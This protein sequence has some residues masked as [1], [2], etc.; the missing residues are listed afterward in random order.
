ME[1]VTINMEQPAPTSQGTPMQS[2]SLDANT[3]S[4]LVASRPIMI[5]KFMP[6]DVDLWYNQVEACFAVHGLVDQR[7]KYFQ[8]V[9]S[10]DPDVIK[11]VT[12]YVSQP[13]GHG[14]FQGLVDALRSAF[15]KSEGDKLDELFALT[16]GDQKPSH[17]YY[18]MRRLWL[19]NDPDASKVLRQLF[20]RKLPS[21]VAVLLR[22][23]TNIDLKDFLKAADDM[24]DQCKQ[25]LVFARQVQ[26]K[27]DM[28]GD[29]HPVDSITT[30]KVSKNKL[31]HDKRYP[32]F[33]TE[34]ICN[35]H[36]RWG[37]KA[38]KCRPGCKFPGATK[39]KVNSV[40]PR[41][42]AGIQNKIT[43]PPTWNQHKAVR[44]DQ[45][46]NGKQ[47][48]IDTGSAYSILPVQPHEKRTK[49]NNDMFKG[50]QGVAIP[51]YGQ[52]EIVVDIGTGRKLKHKFFI[53]GVEDPLLGMDFLLEHRLAVD[54]IHDCLIDVDT[55]ISTPVNAVFINKVTSSS[56][57]TGDL[58]R[59]WN[60]FPGLCE[61]TIEKLSSKP[62]HNVEHDIIVKPGTRPTHAKARRL[63]GQKLDA[64]REEINIMLRLGIIQPS[65]SDWASP[66]H[67]VPKGEG[68]YRPCGDFRELNAATVPDRYPLPHI[69]D[70]TRDLAGSKIFSKVDLVRAFHQVPLSKEA[71]PKTAIIT[72]FGLFEFVRMPFG[73]C[74][75]AQAFQ[76]FMDIVTKGLEGVFVYVD[77]ILVVSKN[78]TEHEQRLRQLFARLSQYG[79][80]VNPSKSVLGTTEVTFLG[81]T[82]NEHGV[83]P[84]EDKVKAI[85][86][87]P[88]PTTFGKLSEFLGMTNFYHRFIPQCSE[89]AK[90]LYDILK[91]HVAKKNSKKGIPV[92][93]WKK[94]QQNAF[95]NLKQALSEAV[96][97]TYPDPNAMTRLVTDA[98]DVAVGA[99]LE[100]H[101]EGN[102]KPISFYSR[103]LRTPEQKYS[104]YDRELLSIKLAL[105]NFRHIVEGISSEQFH[106]ATDHK[107]LT[108]G[109]NFSVT[110]QNPSQLN[111]ILRTWQY[112]SELTTD[113]RHISGKANPVADALSRNPVNSI[114]HKSLLSLIE[115]EQK[116]IN[117]R[118]TN[119]EKWPDHWDIQKH[120]G[121]TL[122][123][124]TR[125]QR[126][127]PVIPESI[128]KTV[129]SQIHNV[130]HAGVKATK[131]AISSSFVW[132][133]MSA[134]IADWVR[135]C[136]DCQSSKI[137]KHHKAPLNQLPH[138]TGKFQ[139]IH[140]D[141]VG[142]LPVNDG[143]SYL[144]TV[145]DRFSRWPAAIPI[146][147][148]T[149]QDCARALIEGWIQHYGTPRSMVTD[150]GRQFTSSMWQEVCNMIGTTHELT[151]AYHPQANGMVERFHR[152]LKTCLKAKAY[153]ERWLQAL[154]LIMLGIR[155]AVKEDIGV[156]A[157]DIV[158]GQQLRLPSAFFPDEP[159]QE[160]GNYVSDLQNYMANMKYHVPKWHGREHDS[161][162][163]LRN[164]DT[165]THVFVLESGIKTPLQKPYKGPFEVKE[166][167]P[168]FYKILLPNGRTDNVS[169]DRLKPAYSS[170]M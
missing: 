118:P 23:I 41:S 33:N 2:T 92:A 106:V 15:A 46:V 138:P 62:I 10:L 65:K 102:W 89:L 145:V 152:Q 76:R 149:S 59:L 54:P 39:E 11:H 93:L 114:A 162:Q 168:K 5:P 132:P 137:Q 64:A 45:K 19:D 40:S 136:Q 111:R 120:Y 17:L 38:F 84:K 67:V 115:E 87:F 44:L 18:S 151:S 52:K 50:A 75:A 117:M 66:L 165:C 99:V 1:Q 72:P 70:F 82:I 170:A 131:R 135:Q 100:Q 4:R 85:T 127:R 20:I 109:K 125:A 95:L 154:P 148:I 164:L 101:I 134:D 22:S 12:A 153:N 112:I 32:M 158:Y 57:Y 108:T 48:L 55:C 77:D 107:P 128:T 73:L 74:N 34:G 94:E 122:A 27:D 133:N 147:G 69:Q 166:R 141:I 56:G 53:A 169:V 71:I 150:R 13:D 88:T 123:V 124:D 110:S 113:I 160:L 129:F 21:H 8:T 28:P 9:A 97:L 161:P 24:T 3:M 80:I 61:A 26:S 126:P 121:H 68:S 47:I 7:Q 159:I 146:K 139:A 29:A 63:F 90:P 43:L 119:D 31:S 163:I 130:A 98:S 116:K 35:Y 142:P 143:F 105:Q 30:S 155:T 81:F 79:L 167:N 42:E 78:K 16:L 49:P 14:E 140:V 156:S 6:F 83:K 104:T 51:V 25:D 157:A 37:S 103:S 36:A 91:Q 144:L 58:K 86:A 60:E 96:I